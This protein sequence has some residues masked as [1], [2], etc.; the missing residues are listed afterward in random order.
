MQICEEMINLPVRTVQLKLMAETMWKEFLTVDWS[1][2]QKLVG[3]SEAEG[4]SEGWLLGCQ[5]TDGASEGID[6]GSPDVLGSSLGWPL[7][8]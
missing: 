8:S 2:N 6:D 1:A 4:V 3:Q 5:L 7:G